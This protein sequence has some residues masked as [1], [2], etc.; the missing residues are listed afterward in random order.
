MS[1]TKFR[2]VHDQ[3]SHINGLFGFRLLNDT[4]CRICHENQENDQRLDESR[5]T[6]VRVFHKSKDE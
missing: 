1:D 3:Y 5:G 6:A 4:D 2:Q